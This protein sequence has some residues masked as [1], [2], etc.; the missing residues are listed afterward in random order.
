MAIDPAALRPGAGPA[1]GGSIAP[2]AAERLA[3]DPRLRVGALAVGQEVGARVLTDTA[4][5]RHA[6]L[7]DGR[8]VVLQ[9]PVAVLA[10][11]Q[12]RL[13]VVARDP[14][15][16]LVPREAA[17]RVSGAATA[18]T[19]AAGQGAQAAVEGEVVLSPGAR[20]LDRLIAG[21]ADTAKASTGVAAGAAGARSPAAGSAELERAALAL[22]PAAMASEPDA[23]VG[24]LARALASALGGSG[25]F[26]E[27]HQAQWVAGDRSLES[28]RAEPQGQ[29]PPLAGPA[30]TA[31]AASAAAASSPAAAD[32]RAAAAPSPASP[33][34]SSSPAAVLE[35]RVDT[36]LAPLVTQQ[37]GVLESR[38]LPWSGLAFPG[39]PL[40]IDLQQVEDEGAES[41]EPGDTG[42]W[43]TR[44]R[45]DLPRLGTVE[46]Q[47]LVRAGQV[48][49]SVRAASASAGA[50]MDA[51]R[52]ALATRLEAAGL[53]VGAL[54]VQSR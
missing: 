23:L 4:A 28:L 19:P 43:A 54:E 6:V 15:L 38:V 3:F 30:S 53:Q 16:V 25:L 41:G 32:L 24:T 10:G 7:I 40:R 17:A 9:L 22:A 5:G 27:S 39:V 2:T 11:Q 1:R 13:A 21:I 20:A 49:L 18:D 44:L 37:L 33:G 50:E 29:R 31:A 34:T 36:A 42:G 35:G 52:E 26:Y 12:L 8:P 46:A 51:A 47:L 48:V 45:I 14:A